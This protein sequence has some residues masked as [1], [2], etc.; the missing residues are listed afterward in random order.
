[1][2]ENATPNEQQTTLKQR[3]TK[4][5]IPEGTHRQTLELVA[6]QVQLL[7]LLQVA[8]VL[9]KVLQAVLGQ[10]QPREMCQ[11]AEGLLDM[12]HYFGDLKD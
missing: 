12:F 1:M 4:S 11:F 5:P 9:R 8:E 6:V 10:V 3:K 2:R 7:Q